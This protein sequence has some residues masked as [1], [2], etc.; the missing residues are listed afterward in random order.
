[1]ERIVE[2]LEK[3]RKLKVGLVSKKKIQELKDE[4]EF[5]NDVICEVNSLNKLLGKNYSGK[6]RFD[7]CEEEDININELKLK[8]KKIRDKLKL[9]WF[10]ANS[11]LGKTTTEIERKLSLED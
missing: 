2:K 10:R 8:N 11:S 1:M 7:I 6:F 3:L 4:C 9:E 5:N